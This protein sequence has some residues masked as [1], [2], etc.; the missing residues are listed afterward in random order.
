VVRESG[1]VIAAALK[2]SSAG[3]LSRWW[4]GRK[5]LIS[6]LK[7]SKRRVSS[8]KKLEIR[9]HLEGEL[10]IT[11]AELFAASVIVF[12]IDAASSGIEGDF[13]TAVFPVARKLLAR[14]VDQGAFLIMSYALGASL[15]SLTDFIKSINR[16]SKSNSSLLEKLAVASVVEHLISLSS[17]VSSCVKVELEKLL[18]QESISV[19]SGTSGDLS[20]GAGDFSVQFGN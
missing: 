9:G 8:F 20:L 16:S 5:A 14:N 19:S 15:V 17:V 4:A 10:V 18:D 13:V 3:S 11:A 7:S 1:R 12:A 2:I 6:K